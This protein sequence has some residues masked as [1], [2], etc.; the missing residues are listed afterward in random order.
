[1]RININERFEED[2]QEGFEIIKKIGGWFLT[3][4][5]I[6]LASPFALIGRCK[7]KWFKK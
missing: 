1:M 2:A 5:V 6:I 4:I 3:S 7:R